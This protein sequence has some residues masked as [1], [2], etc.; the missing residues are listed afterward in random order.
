MMGRMVRKQIYIS[1]EQERALKAEA[2]TRGVSEAALIRERLSEARAKSGRAF[3]P[4]LH[5]ELMAA[6]QHVI[7]TADP[8]DPSR[9]HPFNREELYDDDEPLGGSDASRHERPRVRRNAGGRTKTV[10]SRSARG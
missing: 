5:A 6:L 4:Q 1:Q 9:D 10:A 3:D 7:D 2:A 8:T